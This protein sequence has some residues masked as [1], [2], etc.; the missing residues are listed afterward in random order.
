[1]A[2]S[3]IAETI[4][5]IAAEDLAIFTFVFIDTSGEAAETNAE[6]DAVVGVCM[7]TVLA[8]QNVPIMTKFGAVVPIRV[9]GAHTAGDVISAGAA[10]EAVSAGAAGELTAGV[11]L[12]TST[13]DQ[14]LVDLLF[15]V[16]RI[17]A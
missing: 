11:I 14:D 7:E 16:M 6:D 12:T 17:P 9:D 4:T 8:G 10:G 15:Q 5:R 3:Q 1:M 13:A 2:T